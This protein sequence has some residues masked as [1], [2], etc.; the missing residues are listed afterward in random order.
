MNQH[1]ESVVSLRLQLISAH[2]VVWSVGIER[3]CKFG[4]GVIQL[5][6]VFEGGGRFISARLNDFTFTN[7]YSCAM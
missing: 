4:H 1:S 6:C 3:V 2:R 7:G 5:V